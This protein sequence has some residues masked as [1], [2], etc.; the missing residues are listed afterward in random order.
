MRPFLFAVLFASVASAAQA[1]SN[2]HST[3]PPVVNEVARGEFVVKLLPL[4]FEG[5]AEGSALGRMSID[6]TISGDLVA[7]SKGQ[8]LSAMTLTQGSAGYVAME[9]VEGSL[10]GKKGTF[11]LQH[12]GT[13]NQGSPSLSVTVVPDS[14]T[15]ELVGLAGDFNIHITAGKHSYEFEYTLP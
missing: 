1:H 6:K 9:I 12:T 11:V 4:A 8:M 3:R 2:Q 13:M 5:Q 7:T 10:K 14:G 15:G